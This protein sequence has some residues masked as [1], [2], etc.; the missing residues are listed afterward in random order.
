MNEIWVLLHNNNNNNK[1]FGKYVWFEYTLFG[2]NRAITGLRSMYIILMWCLGVCGGGSYGL[3]FAKTLD[4]MKSCRRHCGYPWNFRKFVSI[5][6]PIRVK[7]RREKERVKIPIEN[8]GKKFKMF[9][10]F[11]SRSQS[12][13]ISLYRHSYDAS[14]GIIINNI[15]TETIRIHQHNTSR[16]TIFQFI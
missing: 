2:G 1:G 11:G 13:S 12:V 16:I 14:I 10:R 9:M 5:D 4:E 8:F 6:P 3:I 15:L 7:S